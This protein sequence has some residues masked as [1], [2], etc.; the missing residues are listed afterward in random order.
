MATRNNRRDARERAIAY[1]VDWVPIPRL[2]AEVKG[3]TSKRLDYM[4]EAGEMTRAGDL[5]RGVPHEAERQRKVPPQA[6]QVPSV[7][8]YARRFA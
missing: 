5:V 4:L 6:L 1:A 3:M 2:M 7:W 8:A